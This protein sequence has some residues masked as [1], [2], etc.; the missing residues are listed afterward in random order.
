[1]RGWP[2]LHHE[3]QDLVTRTPPLIS[4]RSVTLAG[5]HVTPLMVPT[6][7]MTS[8]TPGSRKETIF[9]MQQDDVKRTPHVNTTH[10]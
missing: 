7:F 1:M 6:H 3:G 10:R 2:Y 8:S 4:H 5:T 9:S